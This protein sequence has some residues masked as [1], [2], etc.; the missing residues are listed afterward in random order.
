MN[1]K[2]VTIIILILTVCIFFLSSCT[3]DIYTDENCPYVVEEKSFFDDFAVMDGQVFFQ[4]RLLVENPYN[5]DITVEI[6]GDFGRDVTSKLVIERN[7][8]GYQVENMSSH[9]FVLSP[10]KNDLN[11][12]FV[13][14]HGTSNQKQDRLL[15]DDIVVVI[16]NDI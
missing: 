12:V 6:F 15:P 10:G 16:L 5:K 11:V 3:S 4:Y 8:V 9:E 14:T 7:L 2:K 1:N 13:G